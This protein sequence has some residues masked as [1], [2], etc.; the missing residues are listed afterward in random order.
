[1]TLGTKIITAALGAV[2]ASVFVGLVVQRHVIR[3]QGIELTHDTM[4]AVLIEA[5]N[6]RQSV[7]DLNQQKAFDRPALI[8]EY[9]KSGNLRSSTIYQTIPV[10]A[11]WKA[12]DQA[13]QKEGFEFR[14]P[15]HQARNEKN[16]P[17]ADEEEILGQLEQ[18]RTN[19]Y[20]KVDKARNE[21]VYARPIVLTEDCLACHGDPKTSPSGDGKDIVGF[22]MENWKAGEVHGAFVLKS[23]LDHV[24][25]VV[26]AGIKNT[27][28]WVLPMALL[29]G[30]ALYFLNQFQIVRPLT[31]TINNI[32]L[33]S[34][35]T[36]SAAGQVSSASQALAEGASEQAASLEE[37]S[38]SLEEL[39]SMT[40]RNA[41]NAQMANEL[42]KEARSAADK[43]A[44]DIQTMSAAMGAIKVSSDDISQI[45]KTIDEIAFQTNILALNA[46]VEAARAGEAG[47]GFAVVADEV[48][49][50]AQRCALAAKETTGK[51]EG[52]ITK[53]GQGVEICNQVAQT[54]NA[55]VLKVRQVDELVTEVAGASNEQTQGIGQINTAV[56]QM[57][58]VTQSNAASAEECA[59]AAEQLSAQSFTTKQSVMELMVLVDGHT[60]HATASTISPKQNGVIRATVP[61]ANRPVSTNGKASHSSSAVKAKTAARNQIPLAGDF[62]D[63]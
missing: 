32:N 6:V 10:V 31:A 60:H 20:F 27:L 47:M 14:I 52:A 33:A 23:K 51:I 4:R 24:D 26:N 12:I 13:A 45:I 49:N 16:N 28:F 46:A 61:F 19:E 63:F 9:K 48:R 42:A 11:A 50:L 41:E 1:M 44:A 57:D 7:S 2:A 8:Q 62:K 5:E 40:K 56:V 15:K 58:K 59:A 39:S 3:N 22:A 18:G 30:A 25:S 35:Q 34:E 36:N 55:I 43:G 37:S 54:L 21:I 17:T 38:A 53:T 29:I